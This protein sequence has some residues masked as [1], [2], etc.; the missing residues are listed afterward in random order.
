MCI[1]KTNTLTETIKHTKLESSKLD[2]EWDNCDYVSIDDLTNCD[3]NDT[4][5]NILQ[6]NVRGILSK[7]HDLTELLSTVA[8][9]K[10]DAVVLCETWLTDTNT[11]CLLIPGY[12]YEG[13]VRSNKKGGGVGFLIRNDLKYRRKTEL[14]IK[15]EILENS[16][17]ELKCNKENILIG[18]LYRP[19]NTNEKQFLASYKRIITKLSKQKLP[20][21]IGLDHNMDLLKIDHHEP[22]SQFVELTLD[23]GLI[24][25]VTRPTRITHTS[26]TL[27][28]NVFI[29]AKIHHNSR[30]SILAIDLSD[31]LP[32]L[33]T[34]PD[35]FVTK[36]TAIKKEVRKLTDP[37]IAKINTDLENL[38]WDS[39]LKV[40]K[41]DV[42][43]NK[44]KTMNEICNNT[45]PNL[46]KGVRSNNQMKDPYVK[47][48]NNTESDM[49]SNNRFEVFRRTL[50]ETINTHA[51]KKTITLKNT[52]KPTPWLTTGIKKSSARIRKLYKSTLSKDKTTELINIYKTERNLLNKLKRKS[53]LYYYRFKCVEYRN[54][55][56]KLW[57]I[58][59]EVSGKIKDKS[60]VINCIKIDNV[61]TYS[62]I[63]ITNE[64]SKFFSEIGENFANR[65]KASKE[66][67]NYY[68]K[69]MKRFGKSLFLK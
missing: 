7:T 37:K 45:S 46:D 1:S 59:N 43:S 11:N 19:P 15:S 52:H 66:N 5:L 10:I 67:K 39:I 51:P 44:T 13:K 35:I 26:A 40:N 53:K 58:I 27:I 14:E 29:D 57:Q 25:C 20:Y 56:K 55:A 49:T 28:D 34:I 63:K 2:L 12:N 16:F 36:L 3:L 62:S 22:T 65:I 47:C 9:N 21:L 32:S 42:T 54:N 30:F 33:I 18:S 64:F 8:K 31:H 41:L 61:K 48:N 50:M 69:K 38:N 60:T 17:I 4:S 23:K 24:P 68:L 6:Y